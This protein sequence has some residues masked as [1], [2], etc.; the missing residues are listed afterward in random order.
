MAAYICQIGQL[1]A[2]TIACLIGRLF[3]SLYL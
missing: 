3:Y 1:V 2:M